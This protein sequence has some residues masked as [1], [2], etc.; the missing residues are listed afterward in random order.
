[1]HNL[2][3]EDFGIYSDVFMQRHTE[4]SSHCVV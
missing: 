2:V 1:V 3:H 4:I